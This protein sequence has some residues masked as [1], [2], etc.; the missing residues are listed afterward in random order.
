MPCSVTALRLP[1]R[2]ITLAAEK[3]GGD[4]ARLHAPLPELESGELQLPAGVGTGCCRGGV[5]LDFACEVILVGGC[6]LKVTVLLLL[7]CCGGAST[8]LQLPERAAEGAVL[9]AYPWMW[10][11]RSSRWVPAAQP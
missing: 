5:A 10:P 6:N 9:A 1:C 7:C 4:A 2:E 11:S 8:E 3:V